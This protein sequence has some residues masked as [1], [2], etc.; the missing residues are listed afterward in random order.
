MK[1][2]CT[3]NKYLD[4][5]L[6]CN[7]M[8]SNFMDNNQEYSNNFLKKF[9]NAIKSIDNFFIANRFFYSL[10]KIYRYL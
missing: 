1:K 4:P 10:L 5:C 9:E 3:Y 7:L 2:K 6:N 8:D